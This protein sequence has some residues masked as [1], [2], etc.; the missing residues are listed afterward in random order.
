MFAIL[1]GEKAVVGVT[2]VSASE[3]FD[4]APVARI[5]PRQLLW[6]FSKPVSLFRRVED[7][8]AYGWGLVLLLG[9]VI[10][11]GYAEVQTGLIDRT[12]DLEIEKQLAELEKTQFHLIDRMQFRDAMETIRKQGD[13]NKMVARLG[14]VAIKPA[15]LLAS[16]LL[17]S[18]LLYAAVALTGRKPEY[19]TLMG[20]CAY[21]GF[22][23]LAADLLRFGMMLC[24]RTVDV[25]T[26]L[27]L[28]APPGK[29]TWLVAVDPFRIWFW[30]LIA[31]GLV[32]TQQLSRRAAVAACV[33]L[34]LVGS[35]LRIGWEY[36]VP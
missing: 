36:A 12:V 26:S 15:F 13:F 21:S 7:T 29:P 6:V 4:Q 5:G 1:A 20:I 25:G 17:V 32:T 34:C 10:L 14:A 9:L 31:I 3:V 18:S 22:V 30:V 16:F 35:G 27:A 19:H 11:T 2:S 23:V 28:V 8:A 24:Y 33:L